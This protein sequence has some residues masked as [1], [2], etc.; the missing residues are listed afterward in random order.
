MH[1]IVNHTDAHAHSTVRETS[2]L[3]SIFLKKLAQEVPE[4]GNSNLK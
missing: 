2:Y 3:H 4:K 1:L